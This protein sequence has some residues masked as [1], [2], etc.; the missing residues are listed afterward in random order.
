MLSF[1]Y[2]LARAY[3]FR[4][5]AETAH[6]LTLRFLNAAVHAGFACCFAEHVRDSP[7]TV[8]GL[9]FPNCVGLAAGLDKNGD[10]I[11]GL[12]ALG[13]GF[14]E[15]GTVT[16]R[17]QPGNPR[18]RLFRLPQVDALIN[19]MGFNNRGVDALITNLKDTCYRGILG[20]NIGKNADTPIDHAVYD[21]LYCL[22]RVYP[23]ASYIAVNI[24]SPNTKNLRQLQ[25]PDELSAL[26]GLLKGKQH[27]LADFYGRWVPLALKIAPDLDDEQIKLLA[28]TLIKHR[29]DG[30][31]ATNTTISRTGVQSLP[32]SGEDGGLSGRPLFN[33]SNRV[34]QKLHAQ[35]G[36]A[37]PIIGAGGILSGED[38]N[39]KLA[40][41][42]ALVQIYT[43]LIYRG[44]KLVSECIRATAD[45]Y[46]SRIVKF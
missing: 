33:P 3:L 14:I 11:N 19:R 42:A 22:E 41:G 26:L 21:Y 18:A 7:R 25:A 43:G 8:M 34:I 1:L 20:L 40:V 44:P 28:D 38:A 29:I 32:Y 9:I 16:P 5:D 27:R 36:G 4:I 2:P 46:D 6:Y 37:I 10:Y 15:I 45:Y 35:L 39:T 30:V 12:A 31:I 17:P 23:F 24:S 13:F